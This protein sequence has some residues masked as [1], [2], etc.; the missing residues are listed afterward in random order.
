MEDKQPTF[1]NGKICYIELPAGDIEQSAA[2]YE[3]VFGWHI[4][5]NGEGDTSFD[6]AVTEVS[7]TFVKDR[8][9][10]TG[11]GLTIHIMV[12]DMKATVTAIINNGGK[13]I[14]PPD[15]NAPY[16]V[17]SFSDPAGNVLGLYL[18]RN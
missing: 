14:L 8:T 7:G 10:H 9:P 3:N 17:A 1:G 15:M 13:I 11:A 12:Y 5:N 4:R 18:H 6:D 16:V 2:F